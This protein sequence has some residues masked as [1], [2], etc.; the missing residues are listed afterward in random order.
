MKYSYNWLKELSGTK[1]SEKEIA[2]LITMHSFEVEEIENVGSDLDGVV[3]G[4]ILEIEKHPN[5]DKLQLT[6]VT[7][8][9]DILQIVC[10]AHNISVGDKVPV[11]LVGTILPNGIEIKEAEIRGIKSCGML[12][13]QDE[14]GLG[15]D[16]SG[17]IILDREA[18][19]GTPAANLLLE[20][21]TILE[22]KILPDRAHDALNHVGIARE[23][24][25]ITN[26]GEI[27]YDYDGLIL[28]GGKSKKVSVKIENNEICQRYM[29]AVLQDVKV[30]TSPD[31][32][33]NRLENCG[34]RSINNVVDVTNY[35]ML[36]IG[37]PL[38]A[39]DLDK[40][41][42]EIIIRNAEDGEK[43]TILDGT[44]KEL[45]KEDIL[46]ATKKEAI[47]LAGVMGGRDS[48]VSENSKTIVL[49]AA[50][51]N[52]TMIRRTKNRLNLL[53]DAAQRF[54]K[55]ID[56]NLAEK[57]LVRA[58]EILEHIAEAK[59]E[60]FVDQY[61]EKKESWEI[62]LDLEYAEKLLG[63]KIPTAEAKKILTSLGFKVK[64]EGAH[65]LVQV[66]TF[67]IDV[68]TQEDIIEDIGRIYGYEKI[69]PIA[70][71]AEIKLPPMNEKRSFERGLKNI[72]VSQGFSEV[73]NYAFYGPEDAA[74]FTDSK[75]D[76]LELEKPLTPEHIFL[77]VSLLPNI[78][79]NVAE[80]LKREK[81]F[82]IFELGRSFCS[83]ENVLPEEK[84][85]LIGAIASEQ[86]GKKENLDKR[87]L[88]SFYAAKGLVDDFMS[89]LGITDHYY[90]APKE[91]SLNGLN[92]LW[93]KSRVAEIKIKGQDLVL[94]YVG[95]INPFVLNDFNIKDR[96][97]IFEFD[98]N[99]LRNISQGEMEYESLRKYPVV[100]RDI[101]MIVKGGILVDDILAIIQNAGGQMVLDVDL[102]DI[103]DFAD[104]TTSFAFRILLG[105]DDRT[106][107]SAEIDTVI[108]GV[109]QELELNSNIEVRK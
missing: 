90:A 59:F 82:Q 88:S 13:A 21:D 15:T 38:H 83:N 2:S 61:A 71:L 94:G 69:K 16:H 76:H 79:R 26:G 37:Q 3:V 23:I 20:K 8:G 9:K 89:Q 33:K 12:C 4:E 96:I 18:E 106:L 24:A 10:G 51:F 14:L 5:A 56:P 48:G 46:I 81:N 60:G 41:E 57:A 78:L 93:H 65:F 49:E 85:V 92:S 27:D 30:S 105:V 62:K 67:R 99:L 73:L 75:N 25:A 22:I 87:N 7:N 29:A 58:V 40:I 86:K 19:I 39:F 63:E 108:N 64:E 97:A 109:I 77:R 11:A 34:I 6:K 55:G 50:T 28:E 104:G 84:T 98:A 43:I 53:T 74:L 17:I 44:E 91:N 42:S 32:L 31:W 1:M 52:S 80:N 95:E 103:F 107:H 35:V 68:L 72:L 54:E 36:E 70:P 66:P 100:S 101:S 102:F 47:A 45:K